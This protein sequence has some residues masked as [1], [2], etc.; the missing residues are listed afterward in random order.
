M[1]RLQLA[2]LLG[3]GVAVVA[4]AAWMFVGADS[5]AVGSVPNQVELP[6]EQSQPTQPLA[7]STEP[8]STQIAVSTFRERGLERLDGHVV[9]IVLDRD[10]TP[11]AGASI[12]LHEFIGTEPVLNTE[13]AISA[14]ATADGDGRFVIPC[15]PFPSVLL[16]EAEGFLP[17]TCVP[18]SA[19]G[20]QRVVLQRGA[21]HSFRAMDAVNGAALAGVQLRITRGQRLPPCSLIT[22]ANGFAVAHTLL[23]GDQSLRAAAPTHLDQNNV[24][25]SVSASGAGLTELRLERGKSVVGRICSRTTQMAVSGAKVSSA[26]HKFTHSDAEGR[27]ELRGL[28]AEHINLSVVASGYCTAN[29]GALLKGSRTRAEVDWQLQPAASIRGIVVDP[30]GAPLRGASVFPITFD[31]KSLR[32]Q[33]HETSAGGRIATTA[34]DGRFCVDGFVPRDNLLCGVLVDSA[35][36]LPTTSAPVPLQRAGDVG[37]VVVQMQ[38]AQLV[39][40]GIVTDDRGQPVTDVEVQIEHQ[41]AIAVDADSRLRLPLRKKTRTDSSGCFGFA[42]LLPGRG[43]VHCQTQQARASKNYNLLANKPLDPIKIVLQNLE[44]VLV[45]CLDSSGNPVPSASVRIASEQ[46][47]RSYESAVTSADGRATV[48]VVG[49]PPYSVLANAAEFASFQKRGLTPN[50]AGVIDLILNRGSSVQFTV[51]QAGTALIPAEVRVDATPQGKRSSTLG[52]VSPDPQSGLVRLAI[53]EGDQLLSVRCA[54]MLPAERQIQV[55]PETTVDLGQMDLHA[56]ASTDGHVRHVDGRIPEWSRIA[57]R[58]QTRGADPHFRQLVD[59]SWDGWFHAAGLVPGIY[60]IVVETESAPITIFSGIEISESHGRG[61]DLRV[62][63]ESAVHVRFP[64]EWMRARIS[65]DKNSRIQVA[66]ENN[67]RLSWLSSRAFTSKQL[68]ITN[69]DGKPLAL[70][71]GSEDRELGPGWFVSPTRQI[72]IWS[73][74]TELLLHNLPRGEHHTRLLHDERILFEADFEAKL[75]AATLVA[76]ED[77]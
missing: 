57:F 53:R 33:V 29:R 2:L 23:V 24:R 65:A 34:E 6:Q 26:P 5:T 66:A 49:G 60:E 28:A 59:A 36:W 13:L 48:Q 35:P 71:S 63:P 44:R 55:P 1:S 45:R 51:R 21:T 7:D 42:D 77:R 64:A 67:E 39:I 30:R 47:G 62:Q 8:T 32:Q 68:L 43:V 52:V 22:D 73:A 72:P 14:T 20:L 11:I 31:P 56:G 50:A 58:L 46:S 70:I 12:G 40:A 15:P 19:G 25:I 74:G 76:P 37:E 9:G 41:F 61:L 3:F 18:V 38:Q 16:V 54:G 75:G 4:A 69:K 10:G 17:E 27:Y